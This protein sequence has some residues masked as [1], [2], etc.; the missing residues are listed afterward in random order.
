MSRILIKTVG[1]K[2][3]YDFFC[4]FK[5]IFGRRFKNVYIFKI[6]EKI[7]MSVMRVTTNIIEFSSILIKN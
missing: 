4:L 3:S 1:R 6:V 5:N 7:K 2:L